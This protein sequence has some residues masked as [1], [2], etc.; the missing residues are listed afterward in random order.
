MGQTTSELRL[1]AD[2]RYIVVA[3]RAVAG[4]A[5]VAGLHVEALDDLVIAVSQAYE[6]AIV[7][8][9]R[10]AGRGYGQI[11]IVVNLSD[12]GLEVHVR[13]TC[14]RAELEAGREAALAA[15]GAPLHPQHGEHHELALKVMGLFVDEFRYRV[16]ESSGGLR[17]RLTKYRTSSS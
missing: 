9:E 5:S 7:L 4:F 14:S 10:A 13:S 6:N 15:A 8:L 3:K 11:R 12:A 16:D 1:P 17:V 2:R